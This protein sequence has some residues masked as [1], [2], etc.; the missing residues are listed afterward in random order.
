MHNSMRRLYSIHAGDC[1]YCEIELGNIIRKGFFFRRRRRQ[2]S[3]G[4]VDNGI[5]NGGASV[6]NGTTELGHRH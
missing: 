6:G 3:D 4:D 2:I 1:F 5:D